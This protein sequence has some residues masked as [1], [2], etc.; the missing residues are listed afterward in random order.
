MY[1]GRASRSAGRSNVVDSRNA[2][3]IAGIELRPRPG[4]PADRAGRI[5]QRCFEAGLLVR[6]TGDIV[7]LSPPLI[8]ESGHVDRIVTMRGEAIAAEAA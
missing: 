7:A 3:L 8:M 1:R 2:G 6:I 4:R 5:M